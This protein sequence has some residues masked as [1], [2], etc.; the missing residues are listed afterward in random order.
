M[1]YSQ[2]SIQEEHFEILCLSCSFA[3]QACPSLDHTSSLNSKFNIKNWT[4]AQLW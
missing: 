2:I 1:I 3:D 4:Q